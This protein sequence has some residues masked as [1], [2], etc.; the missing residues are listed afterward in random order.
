MNKT[1]PI[2]TYCNTSILGQNDNY[3]QRRKFKKKNLVEPEI[4]RNMLSQK[5][6]I[7]LH[8]LGRTKEWGDGEMRNFTISII[9][10]R[11]IYL[12]VYTHG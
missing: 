3:F 6:E 2:E 7:I 9:Q 8:V 5:S 10:M 4:S 12:L 1:K 11:D